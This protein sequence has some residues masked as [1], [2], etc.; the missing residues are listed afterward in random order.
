MFGYIISTGDCEC[1]GKHGK[2]DT[3]VIND[4]ATGHVFSIGRAVDMYLDLF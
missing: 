4:Q 1:A 3:N 2:N